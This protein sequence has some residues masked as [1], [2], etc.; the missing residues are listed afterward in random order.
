MCVALPGRVVEVA[1]A[2]ARLGRVDVLGTLRTVDLSLLDEVEPGDWV[3]VHLG[4]GIGKLSEAE[5]AETV[6][7]F[8]E[9]GSVLEDAG[10]GWREEA[11]P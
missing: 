9:L 11:E 4:V 1:G 7:L 6:R 5:A 8:E 10:G 3:L 2:E